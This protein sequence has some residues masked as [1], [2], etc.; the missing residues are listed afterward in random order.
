LATFVTSAAQLD[1]VV[2]E[3]LSLQLTETEDK[4]ASTLRVVYNDEAVKN[5][6]TISKLEAKGFQIIW[7][8]RRPD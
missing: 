4:S 1:S 2:R 8:Q 5:A 6:S 3:I 7:E